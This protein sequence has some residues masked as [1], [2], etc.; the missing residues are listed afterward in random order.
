[1]PALLVC[2]A[3]DTSTPVD[4]VRATAARIP[5]AHFEIIAGAG[6]LPCIEAPEPLARLIAGHLEK[7]VHG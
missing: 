7:T 6:H 1:M 3:E 4:L 2:G 5:A